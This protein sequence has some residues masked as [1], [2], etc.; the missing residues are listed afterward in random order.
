MSAVTAGYHGMEVYQPPGRSSLSLEHDW[1]KSPSLPPA[2]K[3]LP[4]PLIERKLGD[5]MMRELPSWLADRI[6]Q[7]P[8][9]GMALLKN[10]WQ[11]YYRRYIDVRK[12]GIGGIAMLLTGY[13][14][15]SY[16]WTYPHL[17]HER[18]RKY[19]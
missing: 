8:Q 1:V 12:G 6:P 10:G 5:V 17:K 14:L 2:I 19:H 11:W 15:I 3:P 13:C 4:V 16:V 9:E 7:S 18:W